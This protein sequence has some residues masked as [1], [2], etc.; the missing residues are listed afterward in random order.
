MISDLDLSAYLDGELDETRR[1]EVESELAGDP[2]LAL[3]LDTLRGDMDRLRRV[4]APLAAQN[5][6][7]RLIA[8]TRPRRSQIL[9]RAAIAALGLAASVVLALWL[10]GVLPVHPQVEPIVAEAIAAR[11]GTMLPDHAATSAELQ[12]PGR[13][14]LLQA[15]LA[16]PLRVPS[17]DKA[18]FALQSLATYDDPHHGRSVEITYRDARQRIFTVYLRAAGTG[19]RFE[20]RQQDGLQVCLWQT[21][22]LGVVMLGDMQAREMLRL[23]SLTYADL[24]F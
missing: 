9:Q 23:A 19:D 13:D 10:G 12:P 16:R 5:L 4:H 15:A 2:S 1:R 11:D 22:S 21:D 24:E 6:P 14:A 3:R 20:L 18:G 8:A 7:A 17:L